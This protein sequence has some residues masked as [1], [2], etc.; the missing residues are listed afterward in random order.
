MQQEMD[1][2]DSW[3]SLNHMVINTKKSKEML[4]GSNKK[5]PPPLQFD[6][7]PVERTVNYYSY[8]LLGLHVT[9]SLQ[10]NE[11]VSSLCSR[12]ASIFSSN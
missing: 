5:N 1:N 8:K 7:Q 3:S 12:R 4:I 11:R 2:V 10:W 6:W 9:G